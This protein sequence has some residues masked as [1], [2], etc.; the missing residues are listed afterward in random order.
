[1]G[2]ARKKM[3]NT[4]VARSRVYGLLTTV[5]RAEPTEA[6]IRDLHGP[7]FSGAFSDLGVDL[8]EA[9][10]TAT[11]NEIVEELALEFTRLFLGPGHHISAHESIYA[12]VD[13][14]LGGLWGA[15]TV[16]VK[17]FIEATGLDYESGFTGLPDHISVELEFMRKL[18]EWEAA[19][20][21]NND[22]ENAKYCLRVQ[23][24]FIEEHLLEWAPKFCDD[25]IDKADTPFYREM[26][27]V[28]RNF[29]EFDH[30]LINESLS[31]EN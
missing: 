23:K 19:R 9:F 8:G 26:A 12:E 1:M 3:S 24:K 6:F 31:R 5:F 11:E 15:K 2:V 18:S 10:H 30:I 29:L 16:E 20:W 22:S 21:S 27:K 28:T 14:E 4:A 13:G 25:V 17:R 7:Q